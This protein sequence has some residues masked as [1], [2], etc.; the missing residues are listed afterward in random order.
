MASTSFDSMRLLA[1][2]ILLSAFISFLGCK[3]QPVDNAFTSDFEEVKN[4]Y[5]RGLKI[6][7]KENDFRVEVRN[8]QDTSKLFGIYYFSSDSGLKNAIQIPISSAGLNSTTFIAYFDK[9]N[10]IDLVA[11]VT[12]ADKAMNDNLQNRL[13]ENK[14]IELTSG[15]ELDFEK[16]LFLHPDIFMAYAYPGS[17]FQKLEKQN[18]P[19][20]YNMEYLENHPLGRAEW[21]KLAGI[22]TG[23][24]DLANQVFD[25]IETKYSELKSRVKGGDT[26][27]VFTGMRYEEIWYA[28][29]SDSYI[30]HYINDAGGK[31]VFDNLSGPGSHEIDYETAL[32]AIST[33]DYW[34]MVTSRRGGFTMNSVLEMD[35]FYSTFKSFQD[36]HVFVCNTAE[37]D[38]FG[39][40]VMEPEVI[41]G[42][43]ISI[44]HPNAMPNHENKYFHLV[45][46]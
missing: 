44:I 3:P 40:A 14:V 23:N 26:P 15:G 37:V 35:P 21:I 34:G 24:M 33:A 41:L 6:F 29:G 43:V 9:L 31:Y 13:K 30:A 5:A 45:G 39:D 4:T 38:Y 18:I 36:S 1:N 7:K 19:V 42:D 28:P 17:D 27:T 32:S 25:E 46:E 11:G 20:V 12:F 22:L 2:A 8:P 10:R 16:V